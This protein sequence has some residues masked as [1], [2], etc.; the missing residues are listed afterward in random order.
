MFVFNA[1]KWNLKPTQAG[2]AG[3]QPSA[4]EK[5]NGSLFLWQVAAGREGAAASRSQHDASRIPAKGCHVWDE[6]IVMQV[7]SSSYNNKYT[8]RARP[9]KRPMT[10]MVYLWIFA[11]PETNITWD[12]LTIY[13]DV[14]VHTTQAIA[15][16][17][18]NSSELHI[19]VFH[20]QSWWRNSVFS[21]ITTRFGCSCLCLSPL[22]SIC[23]HSFKNTTWSMDILFPILSSQIFFLLKLMAWGFLFSSI[24]IS[25]LT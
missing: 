17:L 7:R 2:M 15:F 23:P 13:R 14:C 21:V 11:L 16:L 19:Q 1:W 25:T 10:S 5:R 8:A 18:I 6:N 22:A 3:H 9:R 12:C 4:W 20:T 24:S